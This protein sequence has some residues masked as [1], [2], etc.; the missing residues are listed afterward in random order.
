MRGRTG[1]HDRAHAIVIETVDQ[2][3]RQL[4]RPAESARGD[5]LLGHR[6]GRANV[7]DHHRLRDIH[8]DHEVEPPQLDQAP[9]GAL[10]ARERH[11]DQTEPQSD[12]ERLR[13]PAPGRGRR[14]HLLDHGQLAEPAR[15]LAA[16]TPIVR[17]ERQ[18]RDREGAREHETDRVDEA[19]GNLRSR[20]FASTSSSPIS[21]AA[22][23]ANGTN[24]CLSG[25]R[26]VMVRF[27]VSSFLRTVWKPRSNDS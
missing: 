6:R 17:V 8:R 16:A 5:L 13:E 25:T 4:A 7:I 26:S 9:A 23:A 2:R 20:V 21:S 15:E 3:D 1:E 18:D 24:S 12:E 19:H 11:T 14:D 10:R 22:S 27:V